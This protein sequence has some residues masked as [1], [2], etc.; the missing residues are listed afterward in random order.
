MS[1]LK[2]PYEI[3]VWDDIWDDTN[4]KFVE[5][6]LCVIGTH[7]MTSLNRALEPTLTRNVNGSKKFSFKMY[8]QYADPKTG[9]TIN[10]PFIQYLVS[11]RKVKL[12][13]GTTIITEMIDGQQ[14]EREVDRWY[15]F[16]IKSVNEPS[17]SHLYS[18]ELEDAQV[19]ELSKN[20]F[21]LV[22]DDKLSNNFGTLQYL[23]EKVL[24]G[25]DW[26]VETEV[27]VQKVDDSLV[28]LVTTEEISA[29]HVTDQVNMS[30]GVT[31]EECTIPENA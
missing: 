28:H 11:E 19:Q 12:K 14:T 15:D 7:T 21:S 10:N 31:S 27:S 18:Y 30:A 17:E 9:E 16:I 20:G 22:F 6:R 23:A 25:T 2:K 24:E 13:Y 4:K 8:K 5:R 3:S 26:Q 29:M 1:I